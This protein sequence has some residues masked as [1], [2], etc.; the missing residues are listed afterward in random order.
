VGGGARPAAAVVTGPTRCVAVRGRLRP[1]LPTVAAAC[2]LAACLPEPCLLDVVAARPAVA[3]EPKRTDLLADLPAAGDLAAPAT[4]QTL[5]VLDEADGSVTA[6]DPFDPAKRWIALAAA[7]PSVEA[8]RDQPR[9]SVALACID[10]TNLAVLGRDRAGWSLRVHGVRPG[11]AA[12]P[13]KPAQAISLAAAAAG[14]GAGEA[15]VSPGVCVSPTRDWLAVYGL[16]A[17]APPILRAP[18]EG[19]RVGAASVRGCPVLPAGMRPPAATISL[20]DE[21]VVFAPEREG[22][23]APSVFVAFYRPPDPRR[24]LHLDTGLPVIR[25]AAFRRGDG[26]LWA[27]GGTPGSATTPEGLWRLDARLRR[28]RQAVEPTLVV[29]LDAPHALCCLSERAVVVTHGGT[30]RTVSLFEWSRDDSQPDARNHE[31]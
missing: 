17:A 10:T 14:G 27:V 12:D 23:P 6:V 15:T 30:R 25:D 20:A 1:R 22:L 3:D 2:L 19:A 29:R 4:G 26:T 21:F 28:H 11:V 7:R 31:P 16:P 5:F 8:D 24:L 18:I 9:Q 13:A